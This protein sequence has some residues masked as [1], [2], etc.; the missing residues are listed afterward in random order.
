M[1]WE[2][3]ERTIG[4]NT[5]LK[6]IPFYL[7]VYLLSLLFSPRQEFHVLALNKENKIKVQFS[8]GIDVETTIGTKYPIWRN[9]SLFTIISFF[10]SFPFFSHVKKNF[11][12]APVT[13]ASILRTKT[14]TKSRTLKCMPSIGWISMGV[15]CMEQYSTIECV[16]FA[17]LS[18]CLSNFEKLSLFLA[19]HTI[20]YNT[21]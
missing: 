6:V 15:F 4:F 10:C 9:P 21:I 3:L 2:Y 11:Q 17:S 20:Q 13:Q 12:K 18:L 5:M 14:S 7:F 8:K 19:L 16:L 1:S